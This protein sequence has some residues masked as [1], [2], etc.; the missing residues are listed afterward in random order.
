[1]KTRCLILLCAC[2]LPWLPARGAQLSPTPDA[3][4]QGSFP[5]EALAPYVTLRAPMSHPSVS[6]LKERL[7]ELGYYGNK[8]VNDRYTLDTARFIGDFQRVNGLTPDGVATP[9]LQALFYSDRALPKP[10][11]TPR[12]TAS[13][14]P[15]P[16]PHPT[17]SPYLEPAQP[18]V[19]GDYA[20]AQWQGLRLWFN[21][22]VEN[23]SRTRTIAGFTLSYRGE[24]AAGLPIARWDGSLTLSISYDRPVARGRTVNVGETVLVGFPGLHT[25]RVAVSAI[26]FADGEILTLPE[27]GWAFSAWTLR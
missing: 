18:L 2:C 12:P 4:V 16:T 11:L 19:L 3:A 20:Y 22:E 1:M 26:S 9:E 14:R 27:A 6:Q 21:P 8:V 10:A 25:L 5:P 24:D 23:L 15:S 7:Y 17:S 13:P